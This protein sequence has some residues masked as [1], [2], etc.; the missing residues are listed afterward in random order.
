[1]I[2]CAIFSDNAQAAREYSIIE[3]SLA[4]VVVAISSHGIALEDAIII[5]RSPQ[6][7]LDHLW[8]RLC[9]FPLPAHLIS[10]DPVRNVEDVP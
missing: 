10:W 5:I 8:R 1:M 4:V 7:R 6:T 3:T 9:C 2:S